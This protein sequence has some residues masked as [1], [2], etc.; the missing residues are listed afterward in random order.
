[1]GTAPVTSRKTVKDLG[2]EM[3]L[4]TVK[5]DV[6]KLHAQ[7][8]YD[9]LDGYETRTEDGPA[10]V[11]GLVEEL[12]Q[13]RTY[14]APEIRDRHE[15]LYVTRVMARFPRSSEKDSADQKRA[16][17]YLHRAE[18][19]NDIYGTKD[20]YGITIKRDDGSYQYRAR[21]DLKPVDEEHLAKLRNGVAKFI[22]QYDRDSP[23]WKR[24]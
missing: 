21:T 12:Q 11:P 16:E 8:L 13:G 20:Q 5:T 18:F 15:A 19:F 14:T 7:V 10:H 17:R 23:Y 2:L 9:L 24:S 4:T 1:M 6:G 3:L 22:E